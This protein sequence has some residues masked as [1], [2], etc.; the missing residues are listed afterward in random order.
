M[1]QPTNAIHHSQ[2]PPSLMGEQPRP[3]W[4]TYRREVERLLR[5]GHEGKWVLL[6]GVE[7]VGLFDTM[8]AAADEGYRRFV[9]SGFLVHQV[10][11]FEPILRLRPW[12]YTC[13]TPPT[14]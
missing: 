10:K 3:E 5:E 4:E 9:S 14:P 7:V 11:M 12:I 2:L 13:L 6:K 1:N 8:R